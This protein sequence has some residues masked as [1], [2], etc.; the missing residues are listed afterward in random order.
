MKNLFLFLLIISGVVFGCDPKRP[1]QNERGSKIESSR[2]TSPSSIG[3][4]T[5]S[6]KG[7]AYVLRTAEEV[8]FDNI[9]SFGYY[10]KKS[11]DPIQDDYTHVFRFNSDNTLSLE[12]IE[13]GTGMPFISVYSPLGEWRKELLLK[14]GK[15]IYRYDR[16]W[17]N[18]T[19]TIEGIKENYTLQ[20]LVINGEVIQCKFNSTIYFKRGTSN[21]K[22][23]E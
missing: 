12:K 2:V 18:I 22:L 5:G 15:P 9:Q 3:E 21:I 7:T 13:K 1:V 16:E 8:E 10:Q 19:Q 23:E 11:G 14:G 6:T 20:L 17:S 4:S